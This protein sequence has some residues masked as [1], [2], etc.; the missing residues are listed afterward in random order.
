MRFDLDTVVIEAACRASAMAARVRAAL[1]NV[2][3][4]YVA[5]GRLAARPRPGSSDPFGEGKR[6]LVIMRRRGRFLTGC[7]AASSG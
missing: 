4:N 7:P 1:P 3:V 5:D 2:P 6:R